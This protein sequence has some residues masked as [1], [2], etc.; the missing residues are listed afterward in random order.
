MGKTL[1]RQRVRAW[2]KACQRGMSLIEVLVAIVV[3]SLGVLGAVGMQAASMQASKEV[4][5]QAVAGAMARELAEKMRGNHAVAIEPAAADNPYLLDTT[6]NATTAINAPALNC[7]LQS[8][9]LGTDIAAWDV[10]EWQL[11]MREAL[12]SPRVRICMDTTPF[13]AGV[14]QW[15]CTNTGNVAVLKVSW[16]RVNTKGE[17]DLTSAAATTPLLVLP[18]TAG[19]S[20]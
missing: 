7:Y 3:L 17:L 9:P 12:P 5:Y 6:L 11:R 2:R 16:N 10:Y 8:C 15:N 4:R 14:P 19:S 20:E 18:L 13:V 1:N